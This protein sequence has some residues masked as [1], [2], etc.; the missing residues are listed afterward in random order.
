M[1]CRSL[2]GVRVGPDESLDLM[3]WFLSQSRSVFSNT[4]TAS[5]KHA[6]G[7]SNILCAAVN[8][9]VPY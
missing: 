5:G 8:P 2:G 6:K 4:V 9:A 3:P 1:L 7:I